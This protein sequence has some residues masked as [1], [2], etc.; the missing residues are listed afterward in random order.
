MLA[1]SP[2]RCPARSMA[3]PTQGGVTASL[4]SAQLSY[5]TSSSEDTRSR[6][7]RRM[8]REARAT[9]GRGR[10][11]HVEPTRHHYT[12]IVATSVDDPARFWKLEPE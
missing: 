11:S 2:T 9:V 6:L 7:R 3:I 4:P 8:S 10:S 1:P 12:P 5:P